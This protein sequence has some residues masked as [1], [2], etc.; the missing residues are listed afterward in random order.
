MNILVCLKI[1]SQATYQDSI[2]DSDDRLKGGAVGINPADAYALELALRI[3][4][5][6]KEAMVTVVTM[7]PSFA[8]KVLRDAIATG[9]D[10]ALLI[11]DARAAGSDTLVTSKILA[12]AIKTL[13]EQDVILCGRKAIDSETGHIAPQLSALLGVPVLTSVTKFSITEDKVFAVST[14]DGFTAEY[15]GKM[16]CILSVVNG[17][18]MVRSPTIMGMRRSK[19]A[20]I[21]VLNIDNIGIEASEAGLTGSPTRTVAVESLSFRKGHGIKT[22]DIDSGASELIS[23]AL[24]GVVHE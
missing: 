14:L 17:T 20:A 9:A 7:A 5:V 10:R 6:H 13:P 21:P 16:P 8:E 11:S 12:A 22:C 1:V 4:D 24:G 2:S 3:K 23:R 19:N 18:D 15:Y